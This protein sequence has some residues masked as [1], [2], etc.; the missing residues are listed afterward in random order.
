MADELDSFIPFLFCLK[1]ISL[2]QKRTRKG[3]FFDRFNPCCLSLSLVVGAVL[4]PARPII[5]IPYSASHAPPFS[6][7]NIVYQ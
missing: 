4:L 1:V 7:F 6:L 2:I 5:P 3:F